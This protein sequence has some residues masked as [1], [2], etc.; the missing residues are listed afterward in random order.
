[1]AACVGV[2]CAG[3]VLVTGAPGAACCA[4]PSAVGATGPCAAP[5][6][7]LAPPAIRCAKI[8][9]TLASPPLAAAAAGL[10]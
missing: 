6:L 5:E 9:F 2:A 8:C 1:M 10:I 7:G 4:C 3:G